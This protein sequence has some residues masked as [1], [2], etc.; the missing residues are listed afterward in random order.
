MNNTVIKFEGVSKKFRKSL[1]QSMI[2]GFKDIAKNTFGIPAKTEVLRKGEFWALDNVSFE[3]KKGETLGIIGPNGAGKT[4]ILK[5]IAGILYPDKG[6]VEVN[7]KVGSLI[8]IGAGFHPLLT[9]RENIYVN[10]AILGMSKK[11]I[12]EKIDDIIEFADIGDFIDTPVKYYS[13]GMYV[14]LGFSIA[15]HSNPDILLVDEILA[16]GDY[17]FQMKCFSK[18]KELIKKGITLLIVSHNLENLSRISEKIFYVKKGEIVEKGKTNEVLNK[19][20]QQEKIKFF[21]KDIPEVYST[22][23]IKIKKIEFLNGEEF[24]PYEKVQLKISFCLLKNKIEK[25]RIWVMINTVYNEKIAGTVSDIITLKKEEANEIICEFI[26]PN[27]FPGKYYLTIGIF[28]ESLLTPYIRI[29][30]AKTFTLLPSE[31]NREFKNKDF[32]GILQLESSF[33]KLE[34][35]D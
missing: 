16:V 19:Y 1:R 30:K 35:Y 29:S 18:M 15:I 33:T 34:K 4:T 10:G 23:D 11:E 9:G 22:E 7:G 27:L 21:L 6:K 8:E 28:D 25:V 24:Y 2:Y 3:V 32:L 26:L 12:D 20:Q 14:R 13:S 5:L 31:K 17:N